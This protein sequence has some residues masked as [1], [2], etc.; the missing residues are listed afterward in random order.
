MSRLG[1]DRTNGGY[2]MEIDGGYAI[3]IEE[4]A[5]HDRQQTDIADQSQ[6]NDGVGVVKKPA[7]TR[8]S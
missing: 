3:E 7:T 1:T 8:R 2:A 4:I 6:R 5:D